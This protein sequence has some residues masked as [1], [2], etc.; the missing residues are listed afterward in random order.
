MATEIGVLGLQGAVR[1]HLSS[2]ARLGVE[3]RAVKRVEEL[4]GLSGLI[5]PGGES[6][7]ISLIAGEG[8]LARLQALAD[9]G[10]PFFGTCAGMILLAREIEGQTES[11]IR[12]ID[13]TVARNASGRQVHSFETTLAVDGIGDDIPA[14]FIRAPYITRM[15]PGVQ[16]LARYDGAVVMAREGNV[17]VTSFHPELTDDLRIHRYF[18]EMVENYEREV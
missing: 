7:A 13:I 14:V 15:G 5:L 1:E 16:A 3:A 6:T 10:F 2:L 9:A 4:E 8:F 17:L 12:A 11:Y 18:T